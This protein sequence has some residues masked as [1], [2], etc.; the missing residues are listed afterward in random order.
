MTLEEEA[1]VLEERY[2]EKQRKKWEEE[3]A[4]LLDKKDVHYSDIMFDGKWKYFFFVMKIFF[5]L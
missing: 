4:S 2:K 3:E 5:F 1:H